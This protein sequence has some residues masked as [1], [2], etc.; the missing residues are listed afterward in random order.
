MRLVGS[1]LGSL[2]S[3][4]LLLYESKTLNQSDKVCFWFAFHFNLLTG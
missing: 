2:L 1:Y 4:Y 3:F